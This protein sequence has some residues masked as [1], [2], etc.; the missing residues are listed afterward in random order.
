MTEPGRPDR[1]TNE[2]ATLLAA[3]E[4]G[5]V[6]FTN[7]CIDILGEFQAT[8]RAVTLSQAFDTTIYPRVTDLAGHPDGTT[9]DID[10]DPRIYILVSEQR[11]SYYGEA[12]EF[13]SGLISQYS[14]E[15]EMFYLY[16]QTNLESVAAHEF[17]HLIW[18]NNEVGEQQFTIEGLA[19]YAQYYAGYFAAQS[20]LSSGGLDFLDHPDDSLLYWNTFSED[21]R[22]ARID[23]AGAY[24]L[25]AYIA[26]QYGVD[27][28]RNLIHEPTDGARGIETTLQAAGYSIAFNDLYLDWITTL[29]INQLGFADNRY[30]YRNIDARITSYGNVTLPHF[31]EVYDLHFYG[32]TVHRITSPTDGLNIRI[33][34]PVQNTVGF[35]VAFH[36]ALGWHVQQHLI[37]E[38]VT[39]FTETPIG[40][41]IDDVYIIT[42]YMLANTPNPTWA[43][44]LGP[45]IPITL[46]I[47]SIPPPLILPIANVIAFIV[48]SVALIIYFIKTK[49]ERSTPR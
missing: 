9:G 36:D 28:L 35:I 43:V 3:G 2:L 32:T 46:S 19:C 15:C 18:F 34:K 29:T 7:G 30:G 10:G 4:H 45:T 44:G 25:I 47:T 33:H 20:N 13:P 31:E 12:N 14:N 17:H 49:H 23:Y 48:L 37:P 6:F 41:G 1:Y 40:I 5:A 27:I 24:L 21:G 42:S 26:E 39:L 16:Y 8:N 38:G 11:V 22:P